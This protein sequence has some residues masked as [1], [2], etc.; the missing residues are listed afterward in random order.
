MWFESGIAVAVVEAGSCSSDLTPTLE[1][2]M[3]QGCDPEKKKERI[4]CIV[5]EEEP[6]ALDLVDWLNCHRCVWLDCFPVCIFSRLALSFFFDQSFS[7]DKRQWR[8][9][10]GS[11]LGR[12]LGSCL[13]APRGCWVLSADIVVV[14]TR[15]R[16]CWCLLGRGQGCC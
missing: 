4:L 14:T 10:V 8:T 1:T 15:G 2:S 5:L 3:C 13:V 12:P 16:G 6:K 7:A 11:V 9:W